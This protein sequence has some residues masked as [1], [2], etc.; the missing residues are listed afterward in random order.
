MIS[1]I[2]IMTG[3]MCCAVWLINGALLVVMRLCGA[4]QHTQDRARW[5]RRPVSQLL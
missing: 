2:E 1:A 4:H 5:Q 3:S